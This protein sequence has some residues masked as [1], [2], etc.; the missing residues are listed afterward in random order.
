LIYSNYSRGILLQGV[1]ANNDQT[2]PVIMS[3]R[4]LGNSATITGTVHSVANAEVTVQVFSD[5]QSLTSSRQAF[6]GSTVAK[7]DEQG[8]GTFAGT[9]PLS[10]TN[11]VFNATAT[12]PAGNTSEFS[13]NPAELLNLSARAVVGT[14][15][16]ALIGGVI[17]F[18]GRVV[19]RGL[20]PS[21]AGFG[22]LNPLFDPTLE[23]HD[24]AG[25]Q[26]SNDNWR[27][28][29]AAAIQQSGLAPTYD[30]E[31]AIVPFRSDTPFDATLG[32]APYTAIIRGKNDTT[33]QGLIEFYGFIDA[34]FR[35]LDAGQLPK[36]GNISARAFVGTGDNVLIAGFIIGVGD[37]TTRIVVRAL[38]PSLKAAGVNNPLLDPT[39]TLYDGNGV[40]IQSNDNWADSQADDLQTVGLAPG[41]PA[42]S[43]ILKRLQPGTYTAVVRGK[44]DVTGIA[45][46]EVYRIP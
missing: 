41:N 22:L 37:E 13:R 45:V 19:V 25:A 46:A 11:V 16:N 34:D 38:G 23:M 17:M 5:S 15:D 3:E 9:F 39:L 8:N 42:E 14:G 21:L 10:D 4:V 6:L 35:E 32:F 30:A 44:E 40:L 31:A 36:L 28:T 7:T 33:G 24:S 12:D 2:P 29:Q 43:A 26:M 1:N 27:D 20:G 18:Y